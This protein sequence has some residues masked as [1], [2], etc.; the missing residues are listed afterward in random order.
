MTT[1]TITLQK[2][3]VDPKTECTNPNGYATD[4]CADGHVS[5]RYFRCRKC[6]GCER[7]RV[8]RIRGQV[9]SRIAQNGLKQEEGL[10]WTFGTSLIYNKKNY[11]LFRKYWKRLSDWLRHT[12]PEYTM[13]FR[14]IEAGTKGKRLHVHVVTNIWS[15]YKDF[16]RIR[17]KWGEIVGQKNQNT[18][19]KRVK[20]CKQCKKIV[21]YYK[22]KRHCGHQRFEKVGIKTAILYLTKYLTKE[23]KEALGMRHNYYWGKPLL[24]KW[25]TESVEQQGWNYEANEPHER[26]EIQTNGNGHYRRIGYVYRNVYGMVDGVFKLITK[27]G[28]KVKIKEYWRHTDIVCPYPECDN[29]VV[30]GI[31]WMTFDGAFA[32]LNNIGLD[33]NTIE[34]ILRDVNTRQQEEEG[35]DLS[36]LT[37]KTLLK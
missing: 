19:F 34:E 8:K 10:M 7:W 20:R 31:N 3:I 16:S 37:D 4:V 21:D 13:Y 9:L 1:N 23:Y 24:Y 33:P 36:W 11:E 6:D 15:T 5:T 25:K 32:S 12:Y 27:D 18:N 2:P 26:Y 29:V 28:E 30:K 17:A 14:A 22:V 35:Y